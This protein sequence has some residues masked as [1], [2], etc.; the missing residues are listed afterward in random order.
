[1]IG[2]IRRAPAKAPGLVAFSL[3]PLKSTA[4]E[5]K[6]PIS[7]TIANEPTSAAAS[8]PATMIQW[9]TVRRGR[10]G[11]PPGSWLIRE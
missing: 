1:M 3:G 6:A 5:I 4:Q 10:S 2:L 8:A 7:K 9:R 11:G